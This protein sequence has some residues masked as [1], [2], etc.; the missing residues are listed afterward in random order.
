MMVLQKTKP[1]QQKEI[2]MRRKG[3]KDKEMRIQKCKTNSN[4]PKIFWQY[5]FSFLKVDENDETTKKA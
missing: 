3:Q 2:K 5:V 4:K 1:K